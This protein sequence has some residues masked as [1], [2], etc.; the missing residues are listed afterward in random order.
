MAPGSGMAIKIKIRIRDPDHVS[1]S[2]ETIVWVRILKF[3]NVDPDQ[4]SGI[5]LILYPGRKNS[6][7]GLTS[8]IRNT[9]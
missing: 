9:V 5:F 4:G 1:E 3:F 8:R 6:D 2:L 7:P